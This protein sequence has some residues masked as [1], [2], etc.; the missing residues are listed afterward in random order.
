MDR[1]P[2]ITVATIT[3]IVSAII[4]SMVA[5]GVSFTEDQTTAVMG[6]VAVLSP[7]VVAF[8]ARQFTTP[9]TKEGDVRRSL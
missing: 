8:I 7:F 2:I 1:E 9:V 6:I 3:A 5:F 4:A